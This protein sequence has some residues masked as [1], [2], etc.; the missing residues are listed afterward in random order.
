MTGDGAVQRHSDTTLRFL[1][2]ATDVSYG[3]RIAGGHVL[4]WVDNAGYA[5]ASERPLL[6][7]GVHR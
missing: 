4:A 7:D 6:R 1:A 5:C 2:M 3:E